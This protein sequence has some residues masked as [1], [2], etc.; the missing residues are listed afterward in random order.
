MI[1]SETCMEWENLFWVHRPMLSTQVCD[2][3]IQIGQ[4]HVFSAS[5]DIVVGASLSFVPRSILSCL[6]ELWT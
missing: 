6:S 2:F 1:D 5:G 4:V 3:Q